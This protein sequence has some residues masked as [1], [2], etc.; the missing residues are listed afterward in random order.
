[1][2]TWTRPFCFYTFFPLF[3]L[4]RCSYLRLCPLRS[5]SAFPVSTSLCFYFYLFL[6]PNVSSSHWFCFTLH[7][8]RWFPLP[9]SPILPVCIS[10]CFWFSKFLFLPL[11]L[12]TVSTSYCFRLS[13]CPLP[14]FPFLAVYIFLSSVY[15]S[16]RFCFTLFPLARTRLCCGNMGKSLS[17][18]IP[19]AP[20]PQEKTLSLLIFIALRKEQ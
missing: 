2:S 3:L 4:S 13:L 17:L 6:F 10:Q 5:V 7:Y 18:L 15:T 11:L 16:P 8:F 14:L 1:M 20:Y 19:I 12:P 9:L